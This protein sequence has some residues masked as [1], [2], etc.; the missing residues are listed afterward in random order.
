MFVL[1]CLYESQMR[2]TFMGCC[3][4][5]GILE[6][7]LNSGF[8]FSKMLLLFQLHFSGMSSDIPHH[9]SSNEMIN[10]LMVSMATVLKSLPRPTFITMARY[11]L[12][13]HN[14]LGRI[15]IAILVMMVTMIDIFINDGSFIIRE[16]LDSSYLHQ[17]NML[18]SE[19]D[20][21]LQ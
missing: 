10:N 21:F 13:D 6:K 20:V 1:G 8:Y 3:L 12:F 7:R 2:I 9:V 4:F 18:C 5:L 17:Q 14:C 19:N 16:P 11:A 15:M